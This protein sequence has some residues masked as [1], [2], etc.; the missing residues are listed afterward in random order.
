MVFDTRHETMKR[1]SFIDQMGREIRIGFPPTRIISLV[2]SQTEF[3]ADIGLKNEVVGITKFCIHPEEWYKQKPKIGGTKR[4]SFDAISV[5]NPDLIIG[6]KEE[7]YQEGIQ[8][9]EGS[10][11]V[12]MSD[13]NTLEEALLMM[14]AIGE[15][16]DRL[17]EAS[18]V[19][20]RIEQNF[21]RLAKPTSYKVLY[22]IWRSPWMTA[23]TGTFINDML[24]RNGFSN[25]VKEPRYPEVTADEMRE[26]NP[27]LIFLSSEPFPF[28]EKH[29]EELKAQVPDSRIILV[30]GEMFSWYG[31]RLTKAVE[32]F[33]SIF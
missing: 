19:I 33:N 30:D 29:A 2:P 27:D 31:S 14:R 8:Q 7:N 15:I 24:E 1:R 20:N 17:S 13:I 21:L 18:A 23:G 28:S 25:A 4:F 32:Y 3:L 5:L 22:L 12:W 11:P 16:T 6:N 10:Y 26:L 9:L